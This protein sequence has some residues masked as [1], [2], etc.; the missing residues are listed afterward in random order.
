LR[1]A[2]H[3]PWGGT[4]SL[5]TRTGER[6]PRERAPQERDRVALHVPERVPQEK[7]PQERDPQERDTPK[8]E[9][10]PGERPK[11]ETL[12]RER[13]PSERDPQ[14]RETLKR[15][16]P[17]RERAPGEGGSRRPP[18]RP[19]AL[20]SPR[21]IVSRGVRSKSG[22]WGQSLYTYRINKSPSRGH[23]A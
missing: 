14:E 19:P 20:H 5:Y 22:V 17:K 4:E 12:K 1:V 15:E 10:L 23:I 21:A 18:P 9:R 6:P 11:R 2:L 13:P 8:R 16:A 3:V 7:S